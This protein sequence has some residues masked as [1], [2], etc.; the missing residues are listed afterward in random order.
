MSSVSSDFPSGFSLLGG[1]PTQKQ[2]LA[3]SI[4]FAVAFALLI[5]LVI[6]RIAVKDTRQPILI[7]PVF[8][9]IVRIATYVIRAIE[10]KGNYSEGLFIADQILLL[11]GL[12]PLASTLLSLLHFHVQ[13]NW[14]P[15]PAHPAR[16]SQLDR[17]LR[18]LE[19]ALIVAA[20]LGVVA[21]TKT[22]GAM[23]NPGELSSLKTYRYA[24]IGIT[25]GVIILVP[26]LAALETLQA[27]LPLRPFLFLTGTA[28][29]LV[30]PSL[31]R[32][33]TTLHTPSP[34]APGA[35]AAFYLLSSLPEWLCVAFLLGVDIAALFDIAEGRRKARV[36]K[37]MKKGEW[38][39]V[40]G[41]RG[42][43]EM[44]ETRSAS[45]V[46]EGKV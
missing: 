31:Y 5:P 12:I 9:L 3:A 45:E 37:K 17:L 25:L 28:A 33:I 2:D 7:R 43:Y 4:L 18:L 46:E 27:G 15:T 20:I 38:T 10:A 26:I 41:G 13:R 21:G 6:W 30:I 42:E 40:E 36:A 32:L 39:E 14:E 1:I 22:S 16:K 23:G 34:L 11:L 29:I 44:G 8:V 24:V 19:L 35:K